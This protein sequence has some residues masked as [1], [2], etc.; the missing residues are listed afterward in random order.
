MLGGTAGA[1]T[2]YVCSRL[3]AMIVERTV[4]KRRFW[5][6]VEEVQRGSVPAHYDPAEDEALVW[7]RDKSSK[8]DF[9]NEAPRT[10]ERTRER[11]RTAPQDTTG[12]GKGTRRNA[13]PRKQ[14]SQRPARRAARAKR[15]LRP[16]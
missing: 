2:P 1:W 13:P 14:P 12:A 4:K 10:A 15:L 9:F 7:W 5:W 16:V 11:W 3:D 6:T 8:R